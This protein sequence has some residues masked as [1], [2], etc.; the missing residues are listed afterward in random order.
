M[1]VIVEVVIVALALLLVAAP[2]GDE[3]A[4]ADAAPPV[5]PP[6]EVVPEPPPTSSDGDATRRLIVRAGGLDF[7]EVRDELAA[8]WPDAQ[9]L[10]YGT[11]A[12]ATIG[13]R[14]FAYVEVL[15]EGNGDASISLTV[16]MSDGRAYV[17]SIVPSD[18]QRA[19]SLAL[20]LANLLGAIQDEDV[21]PDRTDVAVPVV[22]A[23]PEP[24][25]TPP[26]EPALD[27]EPEPLASPEPT[28]DPVRPPVR[29]RKTAWQV[30]PR[31]AV[32]LDAGLGPA[33]R[34]SRL[35]AGGA[36]GIDARHRNGLVVG[37]ELR[38]LGRVALDHA[39]VR[40]R[41]H[42]AIGW[43]GR[44]RRIEYGAIVGPSIEPW[45][46]LTDGRGATVASSEGAGWTILYGGAM[47]VMIGWLTPLPTRRSSWLRLGGELD[48]SAAVGGSGK[49]ALIRHPVRGELFGLGG[50]ELGVGIG[51]TWWFDVTRR[52]RTGRGTAGRTE[53]RHGAASVA[54]RPLYA[55]PP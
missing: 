13:D 49:A 35:T 34:R 24:V 54:S 44:G 11:E 50:V 51:A 52:E 42:P 27:P 21:P 20:G 22:P 43:L 14:S 45:R 55:A 16:V 39:L 40:T 17:R 46:L 32:T 33:L 25:V 37:G 10:E 31:A 47:T 41:I 5:L 4:P 38:V 15:G 8:R 18:N 1:R 2:P 36:L 7:A 19:R 48:L 9:I 12:F 6:A 26:P 23:E 29:R 30:G 53:D 3:I 28:P